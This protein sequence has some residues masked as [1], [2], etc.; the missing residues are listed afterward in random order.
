MKSWIA[1][2]LLGVVFFSYSFAQSPGYGF[3]SGWP[4]YV[5]LQFQTANMRLGV[6]LSGYG[7]GGD[8]GLILGEVPLSVP[9]GVSLGGYYGLGIGVGFW[10]V[11]GYTGF[12][13][14]PHAL[15]GAEYQLPGM[16]FS[17]YAELNL[18]VGIGLGDLASWRGIS[19]DFAGRVGV[20][21]R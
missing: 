9:Q 3:Y 14:F 12:Y 20:I 7:V 13:L 6:G 21:F 19:P 5:G 8:A 16:P 17:A 18:G 11:L 10:T 1:A 4:T 15:A 2:F